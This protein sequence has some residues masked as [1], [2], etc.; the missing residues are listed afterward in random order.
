MIVSSSGS[1]EMSRR[2]RANAFTLIELLVV[3]SIIA[4]LVGILLPALARA[5][6]GGRTAVCLSNVRLISVAMTMYAQDDKLGRWVTFVPGSDRKILL[7]PYTDSGKSNTDNNGVQL[8]ICPEQRMKNEADVVVEAGYGLNN[9]LNRAYIQNINKPSETVALAD[10]G[11][12]DDG[13]SI[14]ATHLMPPSRS[15]NPIPANGDGRPNPRHAN[16]LNVGWV[17][18]HA[19]TRKKELPFYPKSPAEWVGGGLGIL[20]AAGSHPTNIANLYNPNYQDTYFD[21]Y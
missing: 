16:M 14:T 17:D 12:R 20:N 7:L 3:I 5:R 21:W 8:W 2:C 4:L 6:T 1:R 11:L 19:D 9:Q 13:Q 18:G 10:A 15:Y